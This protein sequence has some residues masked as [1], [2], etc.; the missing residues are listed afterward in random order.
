MGWVYRHSPY[1]GATFAVHLAVADTVNDQNGNRFWMSQSK[2][3]T[4][5]RTSRKSVNEALA[6]L[7][8]D[9]Y[10]ERR[11]EGPKSTV[12]FVFLFP[13]V[14]VVYDTREVSPPVTPPVTRGD[15]ASNESSHPLSPDVTQTQENPT[16]PK[17]RELRKRRSPRTIPSEAFEP[18]ETHRTIAAELDLDLDAELEAWIDSCQADG[19]TYADHAAAF[20]TWLRR[21]PRYGKARRPATIEELAE[22]RSGPTLVP[23]LEQHRTADRPEWECPAGNPD[24]VDG[25]VE[26]GVGAVRPCACRARGAA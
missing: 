18:N 2:T 15:T 10:L 21:A 24:C 20:R 9:G 23:N 4:K 14:D 26:A 8:A 17:E 22:P 5:A 1:T 3:A 19:R 12:A 7:E 13:D 6:V 11:G 16:D 25:F